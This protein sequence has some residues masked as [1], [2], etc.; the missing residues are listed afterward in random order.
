VLLS[1]RGEQEALRA[2]DEVRAAFPG[3]TVLRCSFFAQN[4]TE[5]AFA[6]DVHAG[7]LAVPVGDVREP[8]IDADDIADAAVAALLEDG[9]EGRLYELT[10]PR[11]LTFAE[12]VGGAARVRT[13][14]MTEFTAGLR[15]SGL[16][17]AE[18]TLLEYLFGEV[19]DGRNASVTD[20]VRRVLGREPREVVR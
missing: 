7:E 2:E 10:G 9:H 4:F 18:V 11:L 17:T 16:G 5:G 1:G 6:P 19:L 8:F 15:A 14:P 20:G 12:A 3:V 13:V